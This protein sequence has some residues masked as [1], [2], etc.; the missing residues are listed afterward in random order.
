MGLEQF[1]DDNST[2]YFGQISKNPWHFESSYLNSEV[3][4]SIFFL[5]SLSFSSYLRCLSSITHPS[6]ENGRLLNEAQLPNAS[7]LSTSNLSTL[8]PIEV[9]KVWKGTQ[10][11][12]GEK[13]WDFKIAKSAKKVPSFRQICPS[14]WKSTFDL[15]REALER[16]TA[17]FFHVFQKLN[18]DANSVGFYFEDHPRTCK[19]LGSPPF[20]SHEKAIWKGNNLVRVTYDHH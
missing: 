20:I 6:L 19:W 18:R 17:D 3:T 2:I 14:G 8:S 1:P 13:R 4:F 10:K 15:L 16:K 7:N 11:S 12:Q 5:K 9:A